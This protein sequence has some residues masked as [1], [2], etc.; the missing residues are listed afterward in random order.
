MVDA[1]FYCPESFTAKRATYS[2]NPVYA[3]KSGGWQTVAV[4][5][6]VSSASA[7]SAGD[8][9][10]ES[11]GA[12]GNMFVREFTGIEDNIINFGKLAEAKMSAN[13]PYALA[14]PGAEFGDKSLE[15][16]TITFEG[17]DVRVDSLPSDAGVKQGNYSFVPTFENNP[18]HKAWILN[19]EGNGFDSW[20]NG[21]PLCFRGYF[22]SVDPEAYAKGEFT[23]STDTQQGAASKKLL[24]IA[25]L[26]LDG[27]VTG[28]TTTQKQSTEIRAAKGGIQISTAQPAKITVFDAEG[29]TVFCDTVNGNKTIA[30]Q[31]GVYV[32]NSRKVLVK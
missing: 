30:L 5:F 25:G 20:T 18:V 2:L 24:R 13:T 17:V 28:M 1:P 21:T 29:K 23:F 6:E 14:V 19:Y 11:V 3:T 31:K 12:S 26:S 8:I 27:E 32:V 10:I 7:S 9:A 4:P 16:E 22:T 15:N